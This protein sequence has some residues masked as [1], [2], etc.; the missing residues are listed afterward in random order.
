[1]RRHRLI[2]LRLNARLDLRNIERQLQRLDADE[3]DAGY[4]RQVE[5][6]VAAVQGFID[7]D[8]AE[9]DPD[10]FQAAMEKMDRGTLRLAE[11]NIA[12][13]LREDPAGAAP[14][15]GD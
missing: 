6:D 14:P 11:L 7:A 13:T 10:A 15:A 2:D 8:D 1:M 12:K 4:R 3:L 5:A 9:I